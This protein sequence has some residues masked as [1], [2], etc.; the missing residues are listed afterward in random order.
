MCVCV[1]FNIYFK[2]LF[3][4]GSF[5][6]EL[7]PLWNAC[8]TVWAFTSIPKS[9]STCL[10]TSRLIVTLPFVTHSTNDQGI[11]LFNNHGLRPLE[12]FALIRYLFLIL[13]TFPT[14]T[15][16]ILAISLC[17]YPLLKHRTSILLLI[18]WLCSCHFLY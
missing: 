12:W 6:C 3:I 4:I 9:C 2:I 18:F 14:L 16:K 11:S 17:T 1:C 8:L 5:Y 10:A 13:W 7:K 15:F